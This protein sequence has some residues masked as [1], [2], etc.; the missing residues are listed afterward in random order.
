MSHPHEPR[1]EFIR[2]LESRVG[3]VARHR[4]PA[5]DVPRWIPRSRPVLA[6]VLVGGVAA[7]MAL[8]GTAVVVAYQ[9]QNVAARD[10]L[11]TTY[12]QRASLAQD[13]YAIA[14]KL[15]KDVQQRVAIGSAPIVE[16]L[17]GRVKMAT[18]L[19]ELQSVQ[20]QVEEVRL[21]GREPVTQLSAPLVG[22]RD[23]VTE[24]WRIEMTVPTMALDAEQQRLTAWQR[25]V[26]AGMANASELEPIRLH[27]KEL[28]ATITGYQRK[29]DI[30]QRFLNKNMDAGLA[31]LRVLE[32]DADQRVALLTGNIELSRQE[33]DRIQARVA[34]GGSPS[35]DALE[36]ALR[37]HQVEFELEKAQYDLELIRRK[38]GQRGR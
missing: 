24:R 15:L 7:S 36:A 16:L 10:L 33:V 30:R 32:V 31:D 29:L 11:L 3:A 25:R 21:T 1:D 22:G 6:L 27:L 4:R 2:D 14:E 18:A 13:Q 5:A 35:L 34:V 20:L 9:A 19:A 37:L 17:D 28:E 23:F 26:S 38:I 8:G 12:Q